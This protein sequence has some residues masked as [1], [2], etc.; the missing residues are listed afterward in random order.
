MTWRLLLSALLVAA[1][2]ARAEVRVFVEDV[3]GEAWIN[4]ECT[5]GEVVRPFALDVTVDQG[6]IVGIS[7]FLTGESTPEQRGCGIF[8]A[9]FRDHI[10]VLSGTEANWDAAG[11]TPMAAVSDSP[12][13]TLPGLG[14]SGV[15]LELGGLWDPFEAAAVPDTAGTLCALQISQTANVSVTANTVRGGIAS[16]SSDVVIDPVFT[17]GAVAPL[18][19]VITSLT[20]VDDTITITFENGE[21]KT[22]T[23]LDGEWTG[24]GNTSGEYS[25]SIAG[26]RQKF[27][28]VQE[29]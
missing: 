7:R 17:G 1:S 4:Y 22:A 13:Q 6:A 15:T 5:A 28:R 24:T 9:A 20:V 10:T 14:S 3:A 26:V 23:T 11:Y 8:P 27:Y 29:Q 21:V 19:P 18:I 2:Y 16:A 25:E 12:A